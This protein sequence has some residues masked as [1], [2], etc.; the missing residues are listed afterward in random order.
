[1]SK[2][3]KKKKDKLYIQEQQT[4]SEDVKEEK[5]NENAKI[6]TL[7][8][9]DSESETTL[10]DAD[11]SLNIPVKE[12][13]TERISARR[14]ERLGDNTAELEEKLADISSQLQDI[15]S[16]RSQ[17]ENEDLI[18]QEKNWLEERTLMLREQ[19]DIERQELFEKQKLLEERRRQQAENMAQNKQMR[20]YNQM[21]EQ[22][23][24]EQIYAL[25]GI[26]LDKVEGMVEYGN[27][28]YQGAVFSMFLMALALCAYI[29]YIEGID[30]SIFFAMLAL[31]GA[32]STVLLHERDGRLQSGLYGAICKLFGLLTTPL[33]LFLYAVYELEF[34]DLTLAI[35]ICAV[36]A[37]VMYIIGSADFF[38]R[39]PYRGTGR[40]SRAARAE[41]KE[42]KRSAAKTV[43][44][45]R[46]AR[47][48]L[49][50]K[51]IRKQEKQAKKLED[52]RRREQEYSEKLEKKMVADKL[53]Q[54]QY[55]ELAEIRRKN[56]EQRAQL[57]DQKVVDFKAR[58]S[59][60]THQNERPA[61][62]N[63]MD[64]ANAVGANLPQ[65]DTVIK[66]ELPGVESKSV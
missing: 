12:S 23:Q 7:I 33:M 3:N 29:G 58:F 16:L 39:N 54:Q 63:N 47:M 53:K 2:K 42:L 22:E 60:W 30:T 37:I 65:E 50:N 62:E 21:H 59:G 52:A 34:M 49:E 35:Y 36:Y 17:L 5:L 25:H 38:L 27:A 61:V 45:N 14:E 19:E 56:R 10:T 24:A 57:R 46:K 8:P 6:T 4:M 40:A 66:D 31:T 26:S 11:K 9:R 18:V 55:E 28:V 44:K 15:Q 13:L 43:K 32:E 20:L 51:L 1:M 41:I 48:S 64:A